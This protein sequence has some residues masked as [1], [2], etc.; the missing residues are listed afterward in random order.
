LQKLAYRIRKKLPFRPASICRAF[1][2]KDGFAEHLDHCRIFTLSSWHGDSCSVGVAP[3]NKALLQFDTSH[4]IELSLCPTYP[5]VMKVYVFEAPG[6]LYGAT[7]SQ[8]GKNLPRDK[9]PWRFLRQVQ[10]DPKQ[11]LVGLDTAMALR[12]IRR[13]GY[14]VAK[15]KIVTTE[16]IH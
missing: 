3:E 9:G 10:L 4:I 12:E 6:H 14:F 16:S 8:S 5:S 7:E 2:K 13:H 15:P 11:P 1:A